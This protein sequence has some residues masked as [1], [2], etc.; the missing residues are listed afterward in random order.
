MDYDVRVEQVGEQPLAVV[1]RRAT[2]QELSRVV[3][4]ACGTVWGLVRAQRI[5][6]AGRH[7]A[8]YLDDAL[9]I[10]VGVE[11]DAPFA[12]QGELVGSALPAGSVATAIHFGPYVGLPDAHNAIRQWCAARAFALA[13]P[14]W[15][16]YGHWK[17]EWNSDATR[18]R[19]DVFYLLKTAPESGV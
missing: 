16:V 5:R 18:I 7:V 10:E 19:T 9:N 1:R 6:G 2:L 14:N 13:G 8:V 12:G 17:E 15:E 4:E 3:P 11:L